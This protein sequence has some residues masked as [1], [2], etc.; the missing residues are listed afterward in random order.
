MIFVD[1]QFIGG[2]SELTKMVKEGD[3]D[4]QEFR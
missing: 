3:I 4:L 2:Y 1:E